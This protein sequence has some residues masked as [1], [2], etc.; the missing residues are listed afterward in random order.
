MAKLSR[1][2]Q[3]IFGS[4]AGANRISKFGSLAAGTPTTYSGS[5]ITPD[6][7]QALSNYLQ[8]WDG[9]ILGSGNPALQDMNAVQWLTTRQ[10]AYLFQSGVAEYDSGTT[11]YTGSICQVSGTLYVSLQDNNT[12]NTPGSSPTYWSNYALAQ[13]TAPT[14][15]KFTSTGTTSGYLFTVTSANATVGAVYTNNGH[16]FTVL[17]TIAGGTQ[18]YTSG[19]L[20]P[21][22]TGTLTKSSGTGDAT[23][24]FS[25]ATAL[26]TYTTPANA[27]YLKVT[28][29]GGG[30]GGGCAGNTNGNAGTISVFGTSLL[31]ASGG[32]A[33]LAAQTGG[34]GGAA[35]LGT[36]LG[37]AYTGASGESGS[38]WTV[39]GSSSISGPRG[40]STPLGGAGPGGLGAG[41][42]PAAVANTGS[43]GGGGGST[44]TTIATGGA[45]GAG[46]FV[47]AILTSPSSTYYYA[48]GTGGTGSSGAGSYGAGGNGAA[49]LILV[50]EFYQ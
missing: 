18:L 14:V 41:A 17:G 10:L 30:G 6:N 7:V 20:A 44:S 45:G 27:L 34:T 25:L 36:A 26:A 23:I 21:T 50:E 29:V 47:H 49:G 38:S 48:V 19:T 33:G 22:A 24:T 11:Y 46:G 28:M 31:T 32:G 3:L 5:T 40:G 15:Q 37:V 9:A 8:G 39:T 1:F 42:A 35:S 2:T 13:R 12:G 4:S 43:G 16:S